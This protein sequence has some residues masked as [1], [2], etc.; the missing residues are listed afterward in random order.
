MHEQLITKLY[1]EL[2]YTELKTNIEKL[3]NFLQSDKSK[4]VNNYHR[5]LLESQLNAMNIYHNCLVLRISALNNEEKQHQENA[6]I[7]NQQVEES[8]PAV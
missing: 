3:F 1:A 8:T 5:I 4:D 7:S 6:S 2:G